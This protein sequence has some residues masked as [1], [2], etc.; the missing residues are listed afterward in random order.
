MRNNSKKPCE[1]S[2]KKELSNSSSMQQL[3]TESEEFFLR[4]SI[5]ILEE[6]IAIETLQDRVPSTEG[7]D[8]IVVAHFHACSCFPSSIVY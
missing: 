1:T 4:H 2:R 6:W 8:I 3:A 7:P 5:G